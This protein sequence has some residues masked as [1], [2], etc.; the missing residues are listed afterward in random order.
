MSYSSNIPQAF[1]CPI[2]LTIMKNPVIDADGNTFEEEAILQWIAVHHNSPIT[3]NPMTRSSIKPNRALK[4]IIEAYLLNPNGNGYGYLTGMTANANNASVEGEVAV[5][6]DR[7][8][9]NIIMIAD[10]SGSMATIASNK[11]L[12]EKMNFTSLDL[13]KH[14]MN[15]IVESLTPHDSISI[16]KFNN[17][18]TQVTDLIPVNTGN[19]SFL[20]DKI[21]ELEFRLKWQKHLRV[22]LMTRFI[23]FYLLMVNLIPIL[24]GVLFQP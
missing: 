2:T 17:V 15:T 7:D 21:A 20:K 14:T 8:P 13:V 16:I 6:L 10:V 12:T 24:L 9:I 11:N 5:A 18:A 22:I 23:F 3:R 4:G 19:K 1:V